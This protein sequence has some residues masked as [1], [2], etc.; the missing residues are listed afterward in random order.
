MVKLSFLKNKNLKNS[1]VGFYSGRSA[2][3]T[4]D[5]AITFFF[6]TEHIQKEMHLNNIMF[7][8][9]Y[10]NNSIFMNALRCHGKVERNGSRGVR[11]WDYFQWIRLFLSE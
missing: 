9:R 5:I 10:Q 7:H 6:L 1:Q 11:L 8:F 2:Q 4:T 3:Q